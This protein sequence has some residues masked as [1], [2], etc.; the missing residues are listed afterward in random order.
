MKTQSTQSKP[1][2]ALISGHICQDYCEDHSKLRN[3]YH[4]ALRKSWQVGDVPWD[5]THEPD[6]SPYATPHEPLSG[7]RDYDELPDPEKI[8]ISWRLHCLEISDILYGEQGA[9]L[10]SAQLVN[11][12][13]DMTAKLFAS[14]QVMD[15]ARHV[16]FFSHYLQHVV[17]HVNPPECRLQTVVDAMVRDQRWDFKLISC[18]ILIESIALARLQELRGTIVIPVM[19]HAIDYIMQ[20]EARHV[21]FGTNSLRDHVERLSCAD[22]QMRSDYVMDQLFNLAGTMNTGA[23]LADE[24][25]WNLPELRRHFRQRRSAKPVL[26][27]GVFRQLRLNLKSAG[28]LTQKTLQRMAM[29]ESGI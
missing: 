14:S 18:Q 28:L 4:L 26:R 10:I 12:M 13:P 24:M 9:L 20:D 25:N 27:E 23:R 17:G 7:F 8:R 3:L 1:F 19:R 2:S 29:I 5:K 16:E 15:E 11:C 6:V 22:I 21:H